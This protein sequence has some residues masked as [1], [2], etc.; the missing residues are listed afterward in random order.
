MDRIEQA[1]P[2]LKGKVEVHSDGDGCKEARMWHIGL[3]VVS[4]VLCAVAGVVLG[5]FVLWCHRK[6]CAKG[7]SGAGHFEMHDESH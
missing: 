4:H 6:Y 5:A 2:E 1:H 7:G 3:L